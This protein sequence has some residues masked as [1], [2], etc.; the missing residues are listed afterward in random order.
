MSVW[1]DVSITMLPFVIRQIKTGATM[2][3]SLKEAV[4]KKT[5]N[6]PQDIY[7]ARAGL[8]PTY[9]AI[10]RITEAVRNTPRT[11]PKQ[12]SS[13]V[14]E[15]KQ[16]GQFVCRFEDLSI[17]MKLIKS[18]RPEGCDPIRCNRRRRQTLAGCLVNRRRG[19]SKRTGSFKRKKKLQ[20]L[21]AGCDALPR[22][23]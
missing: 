7:A 18:Q 14:A 19:R 22:H 3:S 16:A 11:L 4:L 2:D 8:V 10:C 12:G 20:D 15:V 23:R 13:G 1:L 5:L 21:I 9:D 6:I 17:T